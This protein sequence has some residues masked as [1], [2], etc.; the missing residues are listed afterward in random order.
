[1]PHTPEWLLLK[2]NNFTPLLVNNKINI[3]VWYK[4]LWYSRSAL[5]FT[6]S[7]P[8]VP[9]CLVFEDRSTRCSRKSF[10]LLN[11]VCSTEGCLTPLSWM[12]RMCVCVCVRYSA[13]FDRG[14]VKLWIASLLFYHFSLQPSTLVLLFLGGGVKIPFVSP[15][16]GVSGP[17]SIF[18]L[19]QLNTCHLL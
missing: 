14:L 12:V 13:G 8:T 6:Q 17:D 15:S 4:S 7:T 10:F 2:H 16:W 5:L 11:G 3:K 19:Q 1:M 18:V 9:I